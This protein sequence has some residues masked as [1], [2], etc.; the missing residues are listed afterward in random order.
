M[1][2]K[3]TDD[4]REEVHN[5]QLRLDLAEIPA[6]RIAVELVLLRRLA[7]EVRRITPHHL[8]HFAPL[9]RDLLDRI[10]LAG[11]KPAWDQL[12]AEH[13]EQKGLLE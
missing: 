11:Q 6:R 8:R 7:A 3:L 13:F 9:A 1:I 12:T 2:Y 5:L 4:E 10:P